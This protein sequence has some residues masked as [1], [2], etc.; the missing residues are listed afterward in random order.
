MI[1]TNKV[2]IMALTLAKFQ[3]IESS[4]KV[5]LVECEIAQDRLNGKLK[6]TYS[7]GP[8]SDISYGLLLKRYK[9]VCIDES[10]FKRLLALKDYRNYLAHQAFISVL[11]MSIE[12][13]QF[14]GVNPVIID[15]QK[16][17]TE[18]DE[19]VALLI[20]DRNLVIKN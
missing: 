8:L 14:I 9:K 17:N 18:L 7:V 2:V 3:L 4:L 19:C 5:Y 13:K 16:L 11:D 12:Q 15:Y 10:L 1:D 20:Q 6:E